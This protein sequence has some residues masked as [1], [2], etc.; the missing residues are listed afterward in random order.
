MSRK[1]CVKNSI[2]LNTEKPDCKSIRFFYPKYREPF[3]FR[4]TSEI[5]AE[6]KVKK[7]NK[8]AAVKA[9]FYV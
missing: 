7:A 3:N 4:N 8:K 1:N 5:T 6:N 9:A 2:N